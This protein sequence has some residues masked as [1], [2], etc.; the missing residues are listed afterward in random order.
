MGEIHGRYRPARQLR[1]AAIKKVSGRQGK[2]S[3]ND[4]HRG[5]KDEEVKKTRTAAPQTSKQD[6]DMQDCPQESEGR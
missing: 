4:P 2:W 1:N 6:Q 5:G 3:P